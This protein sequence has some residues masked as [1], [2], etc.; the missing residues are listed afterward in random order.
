MLVVL[1]D[2]CTNT[3]FTG[4]TKYL[5][6][7]TVRRGCRDGSVAKSSSVA[8]THGRSA[9]PPVT[10]VPCLVS[11]DTCT[12]VCAEIYTHKE[13]RKEVVRETAYGLR[14]YSVLGEA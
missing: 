1:L 9:Q 2:Y 13:K 4:E 12:C 6:G 8:G 10:P 7:S 3:L 14:R 5:T 11:A